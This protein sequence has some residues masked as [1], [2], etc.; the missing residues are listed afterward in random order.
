MKTE[1]KNKW[2]AALRSGNYI[3]GRNVLVSSGR[4]G[5]YFCCLGVLCEVM[6]YPRE[7]NQYTRLPPESLPEHEE[8]MNVVLNDWA[9]DEVGLTNDAQ[10]DLTILNDNEEWN[11]EQIAEWIEENL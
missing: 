1:L 9:L 2:V 8:I 4:E 6:Q 10:T 5:D 7:G 11:F 3:Q